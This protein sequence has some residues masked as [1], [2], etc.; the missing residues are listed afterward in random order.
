VGRRC[1]FLIW[2]RNIL[3]KHRFNNRSNKL[4][5][6]PWLEMGFSM[7]ITHLRTFIDLRILC[8]SNDEWSHY[9]EWLST[10]RGAGL[11]RAMSYSPHD[12]IENY[13]LSED[14]RLDIRHIRI[15][16]YRHHRQRLLDC[17]WDLCKDGKV[18]RIFLWTHRNF[19]KSQDL[20]RMVEDGMDRSYWWG[21]RCWEL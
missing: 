20:Y 1:E 9:T 5:S 10:S 2:G 8:C 21:S 18:L 15:Q 4:Y 16:S 12:N 17:F 11:R 6:Q 14:I 13:L 19:F 3:L 7:V